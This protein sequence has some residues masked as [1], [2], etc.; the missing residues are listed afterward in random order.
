MMDPKFKSG[1]IGLKLGVPRLRCAESENRNLVS[2]SITVSEILMIVNFSLLSRICSK[3]SSCILHLAFCLK[4]SLQ[5]FSICHQY[6]VVIL[7]QLQSLISSIA[8]KFLVVS[9]FAVRFSCSSI[10]LA[11]AT[12][13][14]R[15]TA[16][17]IFV[18]YSA[19][20]VLVSR[21][22]SRNN[23]SHLYLNISSRILAASNISLIKLFLFSRHCTFQCYDFDDSMYC[24]PN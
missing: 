16:F 7:S 2:L 13:F 19:F 15:E 5:L 4:F 1:P 8:G 9:I 20:P 21:K 12:S 14:H 22:S 3:F 23:Y 11:F 24:L 6:F 10:H 17:S 18:L